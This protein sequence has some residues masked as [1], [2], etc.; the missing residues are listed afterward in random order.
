MT[1]AG[2]IFISRWLSSTYEKI[3]PK[4]KNPA[5]DPGEG[6]ICR[7]SYLTAKYL[8]YAFFQIV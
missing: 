7:V 1:Y 3:S 4:H 2:A 6:Y 5:G 8:E